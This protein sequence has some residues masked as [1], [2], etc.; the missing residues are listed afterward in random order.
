MAL[1]LQ[2]IHRCKK[3]FETDFGPLS[4]HDSLMTPTFVEVAPTSPP[5]DGDLVIVSL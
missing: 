3:E 2:E 1:I 4:E 5:D